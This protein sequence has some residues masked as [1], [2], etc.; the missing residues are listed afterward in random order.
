[1]LQR[2]PTAA[3]AAL[4]HLSPKLLGRATAL[5]DPLVEELPVCIQRCWP[6]SATSTF[7][8]MPAYHEL[9]HRALVDPQR[10][11]DGSL[12]DTLAV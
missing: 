7:W 8:K 3:I 6:P 4:T 10:T 1:M 12:G 5:R 11:P 9:A 2:R